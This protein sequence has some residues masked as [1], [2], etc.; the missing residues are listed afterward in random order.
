MVKVFQG[1]HFINEGSQYIQILFKFGQ[2]YKLTQKI[3]SEDLYI[4]TL[5]TVL[6]THD[7]KPTKAHLLKYQ[8]IRR[9]NTNEMN[10]TTVLLLEVKSEPTFKDIP[11]I[12]DP[13]VIDSL[14]KMIAPNLPGL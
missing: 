7:I 8:M 1:T 9:T 13:S 4:E 11:W 3:L 12:T 5:A 14:V 2:H 10:I 6:K